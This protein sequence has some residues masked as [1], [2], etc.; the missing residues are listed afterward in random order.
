MS[1]V[2]NMRFPKIN[3]ALKCLIRS[4]LLMGLVVP[5]AICAATSP[6]GVSGDIATLVV[7]D[8]HLQVSWVTPSIV[9]VQVTQ[10]ETFVQTNSLMRVPVA[11]DPGKIESKQEGNILEMRSSELVVR[12]DRTT[13]A[14]SYFDL[15]GRQLLAA[16]SSTP[17]TLEK[18]DVIKMVADPESI[19]TVKTA[20]GERE[21]ADRYIRSKAGEAWKAALNFELQDNEALYGLGSDETDDFNLRGKTKRLYQHNM[22]ILIPTLVSTRGYGLLFDAYS[23]MTFTDSAE[24]MSMGFD[25]VDELDYYF[26]RGSDMDGAVAG[27]RQLTGAATIPPRWAFGY[28]QSKERYVSQKDLVDTLQTFRDRKIPIDV[29]VQDWNYWRGGSW[30]SPVPEENRYPDIGEMVEDVHDRHANLMISIWPNPSDRDEPGREL[31]KNGYTLAGSSFV[32]F[33]DPAA[34]RMYFDFVWKYLGQHG[35]DAWWCDST[36]P[37]GSDWGGGERNPNHDE[38]NIEKLAKLMDPRRLNAYGLVDALG[39]SDNWQ[40]KAPGKRLVNLT[41][42][43]YIGSQRAGAILWTGDI[44]AKW[45]TLAKE[46]PA[47]LNFSAAGVPYI[48][49]D[50]G[51]FFVRNGNQWFWSG[52][53]DGGVNDLGYREL[54]TRWLQFGTFLPMFRSHGTD[55]PREPWRFGEPGTPFYDAILSSIHLRYRLLPYFYSLAGAIH[56]EDA[57]FIR[58]LAFAFP[59][60]ATTYDLKTQMLVGDAFMVCPVLKPMH[61]GPNSKPVDGVEKT[62]EVYLPEG[63]GWIDFWTGRAYHGG[64]TITADAPI[65][66]MPIFVRAGSIIPMGPKQQYSGEKPGAPIELRVYPGADGEFVLYEDEGDNTNYENGAYATIPIRWD[67]TKKELTIGKRSGSFP[68][69]VSSRDIRVVWVRPGVGTGID[70]SET[71]DCEGRYAGAKDIVIKAPGS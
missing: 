18:T 63:T 21:V 35:M 15:D 16:D 59:E 40:Q 11:T 55:T 53:F 47:L 71:I 19:R 8:S 12:I 17:Y 58:P 2:K 54:Y 24:G 22:R 23:A 3:F 4:V 27:F 9:R 25:M 64:Q 70:L 31:K 5:L 65:D 66:Q 32:D 44:T 20:D 6:E 14:V 43:G 52:D 36:E 29:I 10:N 56:H 61:Y 46:V 67:N 39:M 41:R 49:T 13:G 34:A 38:Q 37:D 62:R 1:S 42:S 50:I 28:V 48:T 68:G 30:G 69:M 33:F 26:V 45:S 57:S 51:A 60:D 7:G